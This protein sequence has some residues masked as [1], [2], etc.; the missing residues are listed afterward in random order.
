MEVD[1]TSSTTSLATIQSLHNMFVRFGLSE[2]VVTDNGRN[3]VGLKS[4][5]KRMESNTLPLP[6]IILQLTDWL[7][8]RFK[9]LNKD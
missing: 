7:N 4:S 9:R 8:V 1:T 6:H 5:S 2:Q 3:L